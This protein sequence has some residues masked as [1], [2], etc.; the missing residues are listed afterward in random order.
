MQAHLSSLSQMG[1]EIHMAITLTNFKSG[2]SMEY[3]P[4]GSFTVNV[5]FK[6]KLAFVLFE[7]GTGGGTMR[8]DVNSALEAELQEYF[9]TEILS[10]QPKLICEGGYELDNDLE[11]HISEMLDKMENDKHLKQMCRTKTLVKSVDCA[12]GEYK[13]IKVKYTPAFGKQL[14]ARPKVLEVVNERFL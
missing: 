11:L 9:D 4:N 6:G 1:E 5:R 8:Q 12:E 14:N 3:G 13:I 2:P 7:P 10:K